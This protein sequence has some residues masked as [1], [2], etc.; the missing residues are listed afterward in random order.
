MITIERLK[1]LIEKGATVYGI[2][3]DK[4]YEIKLHKEYD[5]KGYYLYFYDKREGTF[6]IDN[7]FETKEGAAWHKEFGCVERPERLELWT[8][9]EISKDFVPLKVA[10]GTYPITGFSHY[11]FEVVVQ[12]NKKI[13]IAIWDSK[14]CISLLYEPLT[15]ETY[16]KACRK[17]VELFRGRK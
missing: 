9:E 4:L 14:A 2:H 7:L 10:S 8:W 3:E 13:Y 16:I 1:E 12:T 15:K 5:I 17:C 6:H 11:L